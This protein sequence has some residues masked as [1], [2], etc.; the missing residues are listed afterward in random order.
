MKSR[1]FT[2]HVQHTRL[3]PVHHQLQYPLYVYCLDLDELAGLDQSLPLFGYNRFRPASIYD[4][5]YLDDGPGSIREKLL[6]YLE[7]GGYAEDI[8]LIFVVT[9]ARYFY[10]I[11]NPVNFYYCFSKNGDLVCTAAEVNNTF[12]ER[13]VYIPRLV[14]EK[15]ADFP[16]RFTTPKEFHVSPFND[17]TGMYEFIFA[18]IRKEL[19]IRLNLYRNNELVFYAELW[20]D[21]LPLTATNQAKILFKHPLLPSLTTVSYTHLRAHET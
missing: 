19:N 14:G 15:A 11:F 3:K 8:S 12:G 18:D 9:S 20:G 7:P 6:R 2:A 17:M 5:D 21:P 1:I 13:H 4:R 16:V 10:Y